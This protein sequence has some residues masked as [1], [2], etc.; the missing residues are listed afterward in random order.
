MYDARLDRLADVL[1]NY[2]VSVKRGDFVYVKGTSGAE[3]AAI[4]VERAVL[5][6]GGFPH[7][8]LL[9]AAYNETLLTFAGD[10]QL[11]FSDPLDVAAMKLAD[12]FIVVWAVANTR[13]LTNVDPKKQALR[14]KGRKRTLDLMLKRGSLPKSD[15][16]HLRSVG[17]GIPT[18]SSA[19]DAEMSL[20]EYADFVFGAGKLNERNP[21]AE[22]KKLSQRQ[23][24]LADVL[25]KGR[26]LHFTAPGT[27]LKVGIKGRKWINCDGRGN[28]PDGEVYTGPIEDAT[29]GHVHYTVP[30]LHQG[31]EVCDIKLRFKA[32]KVIDAT[33]GK[34]EAFLIEMLDQDKGARVLGEIA[35]GTN[36][37]I[38]RSVRDTLFDEKIGGTF[39]AACGAAY[40]K[41]GG[42]NSSG[43]HWDMVCD[44]RK[45]GQVRLDGKVISKNGKF[46]NP[47]WPR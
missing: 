24:R 46:T 30:S 45:G 18:Q 8:H 4:A 26:E 1:V 31:R 2:S 27:D 39:H 28:F 32:G 11:K 6:A 5:Q 7:V 9:P 15:P 23:Q 36:Y 14:G 35:L 12:V 25:N 38:K 22:W 17:T 34:N 41:T 10:E 20:R 37:G 43:L 3:D 40:P 47:A 16:K 33:A 44:L 42:K 19:Q 21:V 13:G 29:E